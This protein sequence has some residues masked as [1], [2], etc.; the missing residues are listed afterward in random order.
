VTTVEGARVDD[1]PEDGER[2]KRQRRYERL[3]TVFISVVCSGLAALAIV[4]TVELHARNDAVDACQLEMQS[5]ALDAAQYDSQADAVLGDPNEK[6]PVKPFDFKG[7]VFEDFEPLIKAQ[8]ITNRRRAGEKARSIRNCN[9]L[10][11][12]PKFFGFI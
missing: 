4:Y 10:F 3:R 2:Y 7:T 5:R 12:R 6:P 8:A 9:Q 1:L 11:E